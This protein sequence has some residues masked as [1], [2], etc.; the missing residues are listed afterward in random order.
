VRSSD[1]YT[2]GGHPE[3]RNH[4]GQGAIDALTDVSAE[5]FSRLAADL[6]AIMRTAPFGSYEF[7]CNDSVPAAPTI[8]AVNS[9]I[10]IR[11]TSYAGDAAPAGFPSAVRN[12]DGDV[13]FTWDAT[14]TDPYGVV[15]NFGVTNPYGSATTGGGSVAKVKLTYTPGGL[16]L[17]IQ[18]VASDGV[19]A[20]QNALGSFSVYS[21]GV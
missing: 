11:T 10:G 7:L 14:C 20:I 8:T 16:T 13:T 15:G 3:K 1:L 17:R 4:L 18:V 5:E 2:Y 9:M 19:T 21:G 6:A 12:G